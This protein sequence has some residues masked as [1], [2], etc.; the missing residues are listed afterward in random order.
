MF[1]TKFEV[2]KW[3]E[4][5]EVAWAKETSSEEK[6][7]LLIPYQ[8]QGETSQGTPKSGSPST[9]SPSIHILGPKHRQVLSS[10]LSM[11]STLLVK[12]RCDSPRNK[13]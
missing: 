4:L 9:E 11:I 8:V 7:S 2:P 6:S 5:E 10:Q 1:K 12:G 13:I 3:L